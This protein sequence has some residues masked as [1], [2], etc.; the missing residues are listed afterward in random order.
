MWLTIL[1]RSDMATNAE[2]ATQV[3]KLQE[4]VRRLTAANGRIRDDIEA[5]KSNYGNLV[6]GVNKNLELLTERF[7]AKA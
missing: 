4:D 3:K 2:L 7:L 6:E 1:R 5:L